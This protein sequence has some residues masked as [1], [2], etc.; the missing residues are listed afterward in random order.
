MPTPGE[1]FAIVVFSIVGFGAFRYG[2]RDGRWQPMVIGM[3]PTGVPVF[4]FLRLVALFGWGVADRGAFYFSGLSWLPGASISL[5][6]GT[7]HLG[8]GHS[9]SEFNPIP[10]HAYPEAR[11]LL[12]IR[13]HFP[14]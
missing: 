6:R 4:R 5:R 13:S 8:R 1:I 12:P 9:S 2:K 14:R 11:R 3:A 7:F 10:Q